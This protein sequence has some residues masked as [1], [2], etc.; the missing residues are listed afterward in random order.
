MGVGTAAHALAS[1]ALDPTE[2]LHVDVDQLPRTPAFIALR[3]LWAESAEM[4]SSLTA[5]SSRCTSVPVTSHCV[6]ER[7]ITESVDETVVRGS[8]DSV[9]AFRGRR[10]R[11]VD[12]EIGTAPFSHLMR[13]SP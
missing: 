12:G 8:D 2:L 13:R 6:P 10:D 9:H 1:A 11:D 3:G 4:P 5:P 7:V